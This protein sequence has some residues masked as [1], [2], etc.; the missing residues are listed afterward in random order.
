MKYESVR[1]QLVKFGKRIADLHLVVGPGGNISAR[2]RNVILIKAS[3]VAFEEA[4]EEDYIP[5]EVA[6]G[7]AF[8]EKGKPSSELPMHLGCYR[9]RSDVKAVVH[10]HS[11]FATGVAS[12]GVALRPM[13]PDFV[14]VIDSEVPT[15]PFVMPCGEELAEA[16]SAAMEKA[17][18]ALLANHGV[19][20]VGAN[21][22]EAFYR[23]VLVEEAA[24][25]LVA[26]TAVGK[27]RFLSE[28]EVAGIRGLDKVQYRIEVL[29]KEK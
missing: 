18:A 22:R 26:G 20:T 24:K 3:G 29:R 21:L 15:L 7:K 14:A 28:E 2:N 4:D 17:N 13:F 27:M 9:V 19:V 11:P 6:S 5:I 12:A 16:V 10:T 1:R 25:A 23:A 8:E